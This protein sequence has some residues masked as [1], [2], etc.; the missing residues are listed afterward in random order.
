MEGYWI[1]AL[2]KIINSRVIYGNIRR[3]EEEGACLSFGC[4]EVRKSSKLKSLFARNFG[5]ATITVNE[6]ASG[7]YCAIKLSQ[8]IGP[9]D[10]CA[11]VAIGTSIGG[12][13]DIASYKGLGGVADFGIITLEIAAYEGSAAASFTGNV[14]RGSI[15][16]EAD[17]A[18]GF[19]GGVHCAGAGYEGGAGVSGVE[20]DEAAVAAAS[21]PGR[22]DAGV[23]D[24]F[25]F[26]EEA[27][28]LLLARPVV[29]M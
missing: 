5:K 14:D 21:A 22:H 29:L 11:T 6:A 10:D 2:L 1:P 17:F 15:A 7:G 27:P 28:P 13:C 8:P 4:G 24:V 16:E 20:L 3:V 23:V 25:G 26:D 12:Y 9:D 19:A 18:A